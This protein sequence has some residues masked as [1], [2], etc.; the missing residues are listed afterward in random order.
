MHPH[1]NSFC[2]FA[3]FRCTENQ[4][5]V[6]RIPCSDQ[7]LNSFNVAEEAITP[8]AP[9]FPYTSASRGTTGRRFLDKTVLKR[10]SSSLRS[11]TDNLLVFSF[12]VCG[13]EPIRR[14][15]PSLPTS[16]D[17]STDPSIAEKVEVSGEETDSA[18]SDFEPEDE[19][20]TSVHVRRRKNPESAA[21]SYHHH[22]SNATVEKSAARGHGN[23]ATHPR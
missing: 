11:L 21:V 15:Q 13:Q 16:A 19:A 14:N 5:Y 18:Q 12:I 17:A 3:L 10:F 22:E 8:P 9:V 23:P 1:F 6:K 4:F 2:Q 20:A 7:N